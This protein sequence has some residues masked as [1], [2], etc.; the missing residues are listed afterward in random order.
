[1][2]HHLQALEH[3]VSNTANGNRIELSR[4]RFNAAR[5]KRAEVGIGPVETEQLEGEFERRELDHFLNHGYSQDISA[6]W[7][8]KA[9]KRAGHLDAGAVQLAPLDGIKTGLPMSCVTADLVWMKCRHFLVTLGI[10]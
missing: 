9:A 6:R 5:I 4:Q 2:P 8:G 3:L 7:K 10:L 1:M